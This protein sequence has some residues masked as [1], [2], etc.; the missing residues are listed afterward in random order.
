MP[1]VINRLCRILIVELQT[2]YI[3][4]ILVTVYL[5]TSFVGYKKLNTIF[6]YLFI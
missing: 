6:L 5:F 2:Q 4:M 3:S 1:Y